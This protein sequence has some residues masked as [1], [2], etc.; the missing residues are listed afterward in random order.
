MLIS[1]VFI[2]ETKGYRFGNTEPY[3]PFTDDIGKLFRSL[4][5]EYGR[6]MGRMYVEPNNEPIGWVFSKKMQYEDS[7]EEYVR[8]VWVKLHDAP[9]TVTKEPHY[10]V[11]GR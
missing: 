4:Q 3:E 2:N 5:R 7:H 9:I 6:C 10:H 11:L 1:E 8:E